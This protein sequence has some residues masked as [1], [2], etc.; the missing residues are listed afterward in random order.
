MP[1]FDPDDCLNRYLV[2]ARSQP[3]LFENPARD[4]YEILLDT[5]KISFAQA[6]AKRFRNMLNLSTGDTRVGILADD[7]YLRVMRDAVRFPDGSYGL[8][9]RLMVPAGVAVLPLLKDKIALIDRFRHGTRRRHLE[10]PRGSISSWLQ[11]EQ[12]A[13]RELKEEIGADATS[14]I[15]LGEV[16][17]S[18]GC[19]DE[20]HKLYLAHIDGIGAPEKHEAIIGIE[21]LP[22][23]RFEKMVESGQITDGPTLAAFLKARL[24]GYL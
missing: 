7:P 17:S 8:Y 16:H 10:A 1:Q 19:L 4:A 22:P 13:R 21:L 12:E 2:L 9:N 23:D 3:G 14:L 5:G 18:T 24:R 6:E 20:V 11:I 15:D